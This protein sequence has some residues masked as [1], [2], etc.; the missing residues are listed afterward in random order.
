[1]DL[2]TLLGALTAVPQLDGARCRGRS[3]LFDPRAYFEPEAK[4]EQRQAEAVAECHQCPALADCRRWLD[5]LPRSARPSGVVAARVIDMAT[6]SRTTSR[7]RE[8]PTAVTA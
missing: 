2:N 8:V 1:M 6:T 5:G 3:E 7:Q 4:L